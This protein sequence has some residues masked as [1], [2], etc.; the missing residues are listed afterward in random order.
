MPRRVVLPIW[1]YVSVTGVLI[2]WMLKAAT[3]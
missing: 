1:L 3:G 2:F